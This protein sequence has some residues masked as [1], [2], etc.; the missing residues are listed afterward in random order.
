MML[1]VALVGVVAALGVSIPSQPSCEHWY[2]SVQAWANSLLAEWD[3]WSATDAAEPRLP[4][5][6]NHIGCEECRLAR[7]R[8]VV[9]ANESLGKD[10]ALV[11]GTGPK[12][13][14]QKKSS[15]GD[16]RVELSQPK[17]VS[18]KPFE[19]TET[20]AALGPIAALV[21]SGTADLRAGG[22]ASI[23]RGNPATA[24][25][26]ESSE[27]ADAAELVIGSDFC[28]LGNEAIAIL[29]ESE[30]SSEDGSDMPITQESFN[31]GFVLSSPR[32]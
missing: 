27:P 30:V 15:D 25:E 4:G 29:A 2:D 10:A 26:A 7:M 32:F 16:L 22:N 21:M 20:A 3:T 14:T 8:L 11:D 28:R 5:T 18:S 13:G 19:L 31:C 23:S 1:R 9:Q 6:A 17:T 12:I 24:T